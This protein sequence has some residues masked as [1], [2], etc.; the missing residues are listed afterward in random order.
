LPRPQYNVKIHFSV[1]SE[2]LG[3]GTAAERP[4]AKRDTHG[5]S[6]TAGALAAPCAPHRPAGPLALARDILAK[7]DSPFFVLNSDIICPYPFREMVQFHRNHGG[8]GTILVTKVEEPSKY[9]VVVCKPGTEQIERFVEKPQV[10]VSN[11]INAGAYIFNPSILN[12][13][14]VRPMS[15]EKEVFPNMAQ[16]GQLYAMD[17]AGFWMDVGQ[18]KDFLTGL[19]LYLSHLAKITPKALAPIGVS[20]D[21]QY[22]V[23]GHVLIVRAGMPRAVLRTVCPLRADHRY[24][25]SM[26]WPAPRQDPS[27]K[28]GKNCRI[29]PAVTIGLNVVIEDGALLWRAS[30]STQPAAT[31]RWRSAI[32]ASDAAWPPAAGV[33]LSKCAIMDNTVVKANSW[34]SS[35]IV[36]WNCTVGKW[37]RAGRGGVVRAACDG[38]AQPAPNRRRGAAPSLRLRSAWRACRSWARTSRF[39]TSSTSTAAGSCRTRAFPRASRSLRL[40]CSCKQIVQ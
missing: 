15:I 32:R 22:E 20:A 7:D 35:S 8:E 40:L 39:R 19:N 37:V 10:F 6:H 26:T 28:I 25:R 18:P 29:G 1:E 30:A 14:E 36:G 5:R 38:P 11:K 27:A 4:R 12:R 31:D 13:I 23:V 9:G 17:L 2:P 33:R 16:D 24:P 21:G 34:I 3:T